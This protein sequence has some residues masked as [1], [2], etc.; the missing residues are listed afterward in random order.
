MKPIPD[1]VPEEFTSLIDR[2]KKS[3]GKEALDK[4]V[5]LAYA[6]LRK[7]AQRYLGFERPDHT[8]QATA[9]VNE[10]YLRMANQTGNDFQNRSHFLAVAAHAM[11]Q[12]LVDHGRAYRSQKRGGGAQKLPSSLIEIVE[13]RDYAQIAIV[14]EALSRLQERDP[15]QAAIVELK[16][17]G[18]LTEE[19]VSEI[20]GIS[21]ITV[22]RDWKMAKAWLHREMTR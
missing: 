22:K 13:K 11:R 21:L 14:D 12:V 16:F 5:P 7:M 4:L 1:P 3:D 6:E 10:A 20:M 2:L 9:L 15:R 17:F 18:G 8:L 19:E